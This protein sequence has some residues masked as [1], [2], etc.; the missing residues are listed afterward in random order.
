MA[1]ESLLGIFDPESDLTRRCE[2]MFPE[3]ET[4]TLEFTPDALN[5]LLG[6][7]ERSW[8][9]LRST[10]VGGVTTVAGVAVSPFFGGVLGV[11]AR[12]GRSRGVVG[13]LT[14]STRL[15]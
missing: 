8:D 14:G 1:C 6:T 11:V 15:I 10:G 3:G 13:L 5:G 12:R 2:I 9:C 4:T 7:G